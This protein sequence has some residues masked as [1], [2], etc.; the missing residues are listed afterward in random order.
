MT[1]ERS[2]TA[3]TAETE[4]EEQSSVC[5]ALR[6]ADDAPFQLEGRYSDEAT[7]VNRLIDCQRRVDE[8]IFDFEMRVN[9]G[10]V[11]GQLES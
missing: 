10:R 2:E 4:N 6:C 7:W 3:T 1:E 5:E 8:V 9:R 11:M